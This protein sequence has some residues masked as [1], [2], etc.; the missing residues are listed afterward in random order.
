MNINTNFESLIS[1]GQIDI[2]KLEYDRVLE[3][4]VI[5]RAT[6]AGKDVD[7]AK[8]VVTRI[9]AW[10][11]STDFYTA[12]ASTQYHESFLGGLC[13]HTLKVASNAL[14]LCKVEKFNAVNEFDAVLVALMHDWCKI[15]FYEPYK[16]NVKNESTGTWESVTAFRYRGAQVPLGHGVTSMFLAQKFFQLS[17]DECA[18]LRWHMGAWRVCESEHSELQSANE[19]YPLVHLIQFADQLSITNY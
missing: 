5:G 9:I 1:N 18:A 4:A 12:P 17:V 6:N 19:N 11:E 16:R 15:N 8:Q 3:E 14:D 13:Y 7:R 2:I 10:L